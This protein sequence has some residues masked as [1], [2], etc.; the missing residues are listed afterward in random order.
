MTFLYNT[1]LRPLF[2]FTLSLSLLRIMSVYL[3][4][5]FNTTHNTDHNHKKNINKK[6]INKIQPN[7]TI[8]LDSYPSSFVFLP[9]SSFLRI[10]F[11]SN[12][13]SILLSPRNGW[14]VWI[15]WSISR[16]R[17]VVLWVRAVRKKNVNTNYSLF[18]F[19]NVFFFAFRLF[20]LVFLF[21]APADSYFMLLKGLFLE[22]A[23][24]THF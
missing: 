5:C 12:L 17:T 1:L 14:V 3:G 4:Q 6:Y 11:H 2:W 10:S 21:I 7:A 22:K 16:C 15:E 8:P 19:T 9:S 13:N 24:T 18:L 23:C 20:S